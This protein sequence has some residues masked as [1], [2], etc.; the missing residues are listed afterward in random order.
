MFWWETGGAIRKIHF[1]S[2]LFFRKIS[3]RMRE[4]A[5]G[6]WARPRGCHLPDL[7]QNWWQSASHQFRFWVAFGVAPQLPPCLFRALYCSLSTYV[8][9]EHAHRTEFPYLACQGCY[10][11]NPISFR[12]FRD[13]QWG[14]LGS[15]VFP[16][17]PCFSFKL[18]Y[19]L[20]VCPQ[21]RNI[22]WHILIILGIVSNFRVFFEIWGSGHC[23]PLIGDCP[24]HFPHV[25]TLYWSI[26]TV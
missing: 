26:S 22:I 24:E 13:F 11:Y 18:L 25:D 2:R 5:A 15:P 20:W 6:S 21:H 19:V 3:A 23:F 7:A 16:W 8:C 12:F 14:T 4:S 9:L 1:R 17:L 10:Q